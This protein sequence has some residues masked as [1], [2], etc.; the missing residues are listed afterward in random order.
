MWQ[1]RVKFFE[2][3]PKRLPLNEK[4]GIKKPRIMTSYVINLFYY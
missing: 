1:K 3:G 2:A 4:E